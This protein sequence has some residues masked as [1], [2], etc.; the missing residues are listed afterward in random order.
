[1]PK[2]SITDEEIALIKAM[3]GRGMKNKN[4]QFFFNRPDR[5]VNSGRI[6]GIKDGNYGNSANISAATDA[7]L[8]AYLL[9]RETA[10]PIGS[11]RVPIMGKVPSP[12][13]GPIDIE[14]LAPMFQQDLNGVWRFKLGE[15]DQHE[16]KL[17]FGFKH[18]G[19]WLRA[20]AALANNRGGYVFFGVHDKEETPLPGLDKS[21][22]VAGM[23]DKV[24]E[25][26]DPA[27]FA[28]KLKTALDPT[29]R[30]QIAKISINEKMIGVFHVEPHASRPVIASCSMPERLIEG[31]I[32]FRYPGQSTR[33]KYSDL[34]GILDARDEQARRDILPMV[35]RLLALGPGKALITNLVDGTLEDGK[36][37][38]VID[39]ALL[40]Q[41]KF[42]KEGDFT[43]TNGAPTLKLVGNVTAL[44]GTSQPVTKL[45]R[46]KVGEDDI[47]RNFLTQQDVHLPESYI[48]QGIDLQ[49]KW[50]P[51][52]YYAKKAGLTP[53]E[54]A[55][56]IASEK[57]SHTGRRDEIVKRLRKRMS[58]KPPKA[59]TKAM[60]ALANQIEQG[61]LS[62]PQTVKEALSF[63]DAV[64]CINKTESSLD[65][66]LATLNATWDLVTANELK[67]IGR[68]SK[69]ICRVDELFFGEM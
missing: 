57:T 23:T 32:Y 66:L 21:Y 64:A 60:R 68:V 10:S 1:V 13:Y 49:R 53:A 15:T 40:D 36:H 54:I 39:P 3:L 42:V 28:M 45:I 25:S 5:A 12:V 43:Q 47:V 55:D 44:D 62:E 58:A 34:R 18:A 2:A 4:I 9:S 56:K 50:L 22:A 63:A 41:I 35:E 65:G 6:T 37:Q 24:F 31:E 67:S 61:T 20:V 30:V 52:F 11:V 19:L 29:P 27:D 48:R 46:D 59:A 7:E 16:C 26:A 33:I 69:A 8:D 14:T 17:N 38:I 51:I